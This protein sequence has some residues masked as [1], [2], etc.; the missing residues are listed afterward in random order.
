M[1]SAQDLIAEEVSY[2]APSSPDSQYSTEDLSVT[3]EDEL[4]GARLEGNGAVY[5]PKPTGALLG[6]LVD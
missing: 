3:Y 5:G 2:E 6:L 4:K 1:C